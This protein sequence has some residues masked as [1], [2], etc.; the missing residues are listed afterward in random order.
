MFALRGQWL[1]V[2]AERGRRERH[3]AF[4]GRRLPG[5]RAASLPVIK[6]GG[7]QAGEPGRP[8][9]ERLPFRKDP[10]VC[11]HFLADLAMSRVASGS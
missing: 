6:A 10:V 7:P 9:R 3:H 4:G 1:R 5:K 2:P 11:A 8:G